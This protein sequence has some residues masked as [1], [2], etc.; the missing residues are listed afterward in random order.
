M[1]GAELIVAALENEGV[2]QIFGV[3]GRRKPRRGRG[4][5]PL[6]DRAGADASRAGGGFH[7]GDAW[8]ADRKARGLH[9]DARSRRAQPDNRR[10]LRA[11]WRHAN[12][13]DHRA[14]GHLEPQ[15]GELSGCRHCFDD[16]AADQDGGS[17]R[18]RRDHSD[19]GAGGVPRRTARA[20]RPGS[21][22]IAGRHRPRGGAR[23]GSDSAPSDRFADRVQ[24]RTGPGGSTHWQRRAT[25]DHAGRRGEPAAA[26]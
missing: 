18:E 16:D 1:N 20:A 14:E 12:G 23:Q 3:P 15:T 7:G 5:A 21:S 10:G 26:F 6:E 2:R 22:R 9:H 13:D 11:A 24:R 8:A 17:D 25:A 19:H 4:V